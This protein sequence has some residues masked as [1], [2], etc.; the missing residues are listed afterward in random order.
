[1]RRLACPALTNMNN[2][3]DDADIKGIA[4]SKNSQHLGSLDL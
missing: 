4:K 1:M 2:Q 3:K